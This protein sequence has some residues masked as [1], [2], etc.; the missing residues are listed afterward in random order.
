MLG[1]AV[2]MTDHP[3]SS[4][5]LGFSAPDIVDE[6]PYATL[7]AQ[8]YGSQHHEMTISAADFA[9]FLPKY[10]WHMEEP[11]C[12]PTA[13]ALYY[14]SRLAKDYVK[15]LISGEGGDEAF[16]GY[17]NYRNMLWLER[18]KGIAKPLNGTLSSSFSFL[19]RFIG[20]RRLSKYL[21]LMNVPLESYYYSRISGPNTFFNSH[22]S[23]LYTKD[24]SHV[25][26]KE[27]SVRPVRRYFGNVGKSSVL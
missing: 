15:V 10:T 19:N 24:F 3:L 9:D 17:P 6:R 23:E 27:F 25:A 14:I 2:G 21:P 8:R 16:A 13:V 20:S 26:N 12:E 7:A 5:T 4:F 11:V 1:L 18:L 22:T